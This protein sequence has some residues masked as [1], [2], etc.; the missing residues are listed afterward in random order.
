[1][2]D[3]GTAAAF[4][5]LGFI[6]VFTGA[7]RAATKDGWKWFVLVGGK[8]SR[9]LSPIEKRLVVAGLTMIGSVLATVFG[10]MLFGVQ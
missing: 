3:S 2:F 7:L 1:M 5:G 6:A 8:P 9:W 4:G 10:Q